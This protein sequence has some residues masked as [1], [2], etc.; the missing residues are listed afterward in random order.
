MRKLDAKRVVVKIGTNTICRGDGTVDQAY[1]EDV[2]RQVKEL[3]LRGVQ[4]IVVT[5]GAIGSGSSEL[6]LDGKNKDVAMKQACAAVGQAILMMAW[7]DA[8][9]RYGLKVGQ[10]L[11][12]YGA[13]SDRAR[14]LDL[15]KAIDEMFRLGVVPV[16][17]ENDVIA[18]DEI[19]E[20]F[21][22]NDKLSALV[23]SKM[24]A[25]L[26]ILLTD[27]DGL[28]DR[29]PEA[30]RDAKLIP[31]VDEITKDI[32]RIAGARKNERSTGGMRT[33]ISA[34]KVA[35][36]SGCGMV[37]ANGHL[38]DAIV[39]VATGEELG[40]LFSPH[41]RYTNRERWI[42]FAC[43]RGK[44]V[45]DE[46]AERAVR[47]GNS[48]LPCGIMAVEGRFKKGDVVRINAFAKGVVNLSSTEIAGLV[49][50]CQKEKEAGRRNGNGRAVVS[51]ENIVLHE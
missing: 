12:T 34:A 30:D 27:V 49:E 38:P 26:L 42:I 17:N 13:F 43:P 29:N 23:A 33:K 40:T 5:S 14:Y 39:R 35:M 41:A 24:D 16:V 4:S 8:F 37:I 10:V 48:L 25:D 22:D 31:V 28:Y 47:E 20:I 51:S 32:E 50:A 36:D 3:Q 11:L 19:E 21:G 6:G 7:R 18:T 15:R 46:G 9:R 44:L 1:L 45:I 2:A